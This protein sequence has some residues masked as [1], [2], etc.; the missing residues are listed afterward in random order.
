ME[1]RQAMDCGASSRRPQG[2]GKAKR[3]GAD[4]CACVM[5]GVRILFLVPIMGLGF[6][7]GLN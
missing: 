5:Y 6:R 2:Q 3:Y 7:F 4:V 1:Q